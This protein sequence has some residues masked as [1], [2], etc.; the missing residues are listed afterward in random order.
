MS[1]GVLGVG[2]IAQ[3]RFPTVVVASDNQSL[4]DGCS[5]SSGGRCRSYTK[6]YRE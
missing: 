4:I 2:E 1:Y 6:T 3:S 5:S